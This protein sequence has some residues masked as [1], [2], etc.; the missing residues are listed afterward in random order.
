MTGRGSSHKEKMRL[1]QKTRHS[2]DFLHFPT[3]EAELAEEGERDEGVGAA[4][5][6]VASDLLQLAQAGLQLSS[7]VV[8]RGQRRS[9]KLP[10]M[11]LPAQVLLYK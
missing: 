5:G 11:L 1:A 10:L 6:Q 2:P 9:L 7:Y 3:D 8:Y 4:H